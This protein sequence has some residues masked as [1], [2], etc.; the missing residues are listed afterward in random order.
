MVL[1]GFDLFVVWVH[2]QLMVIRRL[3]GNLFLTW[4]FGMICAPNHKSRTHSLFYLFVL[5][6]IILFHD[7]L[8][9]LNFQSFALV[10]YF[11][12]KN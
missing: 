7:S 6:D 1:F 5:N 11:E 10:Y 12:R 3:T 9:K 2:L 4:L 8:L